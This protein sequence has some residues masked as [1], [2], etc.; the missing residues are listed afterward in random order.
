MNFFVVAGALIVFAA[1]AVLGLI[2]LSHWAAF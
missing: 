1:V 2:N